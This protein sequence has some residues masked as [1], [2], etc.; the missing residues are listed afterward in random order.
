MREASIIPIGAPGSL[1][2]LPD[3]RGLSAREVVRIL[4]KMGLSARLHGN[5]VVATQTPAAG[6]PIDPGT[7]CELWLER[8]PV[9]VGSIAA[10]Q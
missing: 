2:D 8:V 10:D 4:T 1:H 9:A 5:G 3:F 6:T 7:V